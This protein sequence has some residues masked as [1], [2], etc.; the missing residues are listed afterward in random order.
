VLDTALDTSIEISRFRA[1]ATRFFAGYLWLHVPVLTGL[2]YA[3]HVAWVSVAFIVCVLAMSGTVAALSAPS[4]LWARMVISAALTG[5]AAMLVYAGMGSWQI[6]YHMYFFA[7]YAMLAAY[8]DWRPIALSAV[9]TAVHHFVLAIVFPMAVF[10]DECGLGRVILHA[11]IVGVECGVLFWMTTYVATLFERVARA[12]DASQ[13][14]LRDAESS[15]A[16]TELLSGER[17][18]L[19]GESTRALTVAQ[20]SAADAERSERERQQLREESE[21]ERATLLRNLTGRFNEQIG[22]VVTYVANAATTMSAEASTSRDASRE[23][24]T[25]ALRAANSAQAVSAMIASVA[26]ATEELSAVSEE[27]GRQT[28]QTKRITSTAVDDASRTSTV[29]TSLRDAAGRIGSVVALIDDVASQTNLLALNA[30][31]EAARAGEHGRG[32]AVVA[33]EV[34][35][36]SEQTGSATREIVDVV[37]TMQ[38]AAERAVEAIGGIAATV[39]DIQLIALQVSSAV[40]QQVGATQE[41]SRSV[42]EAAI[43]AAEVSSAMSDVAERGD[44]VTLTAER[45]DTM[46]QELQLQGSRLRADADG[47]IAALNESRSGVPVRMLATAQA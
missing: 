35:K 28:A 4:S 34:K 33:E 30:A 41:I 32:F 3:N 19:L 45:L 27:I 9:I 23:T 14:A 2:A 25:H 1:V 20:S 26:T 42:R 39:S 10:P 11:G 31:I 43:G 6:D 16:R 46:A 12:Q 22:T 29:V 40:E 38:Q 21:R 5:M 15:R 47:F 13:V 8:V 17:E 18:R 44:V 36:L 24:G 37:D 7:L